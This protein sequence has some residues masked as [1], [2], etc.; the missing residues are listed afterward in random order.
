MKKSI[1]FGVTILLCLLITTACS[2]QADD[3]I[4]EKRSIAFSQLY[5]DETGEFS[6]DGYSPAMNHAD[7]T[8]TAGF[9]QNEPV[10]FHGMAATATY[11]FN[12]D[13]LYGVTYTFSTNDLTGNLW[14]ETVTELYTNLC[15]GFDWLPSYKSGSPA[16][17][18]KM[19][20]LWFADG[21]DR[22][23]MLRFT[24]T[25]PTVAGNS[26]NSSSTSISISVI[27]DLPDSPLATASYRMHFKPADD[28][29]VNVADWIPS[30]FVELKYATDDNFMGKAVYDFSSAYLRYG[31]VSK[32]VS[33]QK[34]LNLQ[35]YS[36]KIYDAFR[37]V[38]AQFKLWEA[39]PDSNFV[40]NPYTGHSTHSKG[41]TVDVTLVT[42]EGDPIE[43]PTPFDT[44]SM[45]ADRDYSD[46][47]QEAEKNALILEN[48]MVSG[49]FYTYSREWWHYYDTVTYPVAEEFVPDN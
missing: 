22:M 35:G 41:N 6:L 7:L 26:E 39:V 29:M 3:K 40:A 9:L 34:R 4:S 46:V 33:I 37:P 11:M 44:F 12:Q 43:M 10:V 5:D 24:A 21:P 48:A 1:I 13:R 38:A 47:S 18:Q 32:L 19:S 15:N 23:T 8:A 2:N 17:N 14:T 49:G 36:L 27:A 42:I 25:P 45:Q 16:E 31:T 30:I 28:Q 20:C